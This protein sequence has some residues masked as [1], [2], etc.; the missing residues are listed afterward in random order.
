MKNLIEKFLENTREMR[1]Y[2]AQDKQSGNYQ[3]IYFFLGRDSALCISKN[4]N[5]VLFEFPLAN[6]KINITSPSDFSI[7]LNNNTVFFCQ[8]DMV[9]LHQ[10]EPVPPE[11]VAGE[12]YK[13]KSICDRCDG[14]KCSQFDTLNGRKFKFHS[15]QVSD[16]L[17]EQYDN[18]CKYK[19]EKFKCLQQN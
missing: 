12:K 5:K 6:I 18:Y 15:E 16:E 14:K 7:S 9:V 11:S 1:I 8:D 2:L 10:S 17:L 19:I 3:E 13:Y 4:E